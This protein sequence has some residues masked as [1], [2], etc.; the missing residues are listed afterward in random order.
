MAGARRT[1]PG[2]IVA[3]CVPR[4]VVLL[5]QLLE[6]PRDSSINFCR[7]TPW[8]VLFSVFERKVFG[9]FVLRACLRHYICRLLA[10]PFPVWFGSV[11]FGSGCVCVFYLFVSVSVSVSLFH[12]TQWRARGVDTVEGA[13]PRLLA[14]RK[15]NCHGSQATDPHSLS[16]MG[17]GGPITTELLGCCPLPSKESALS[18]S[19]VRRAP[20]HAGF[21]NNLGALFRSTRAR[22]HQHQAQEKVFLV[23]KICR[24]R[25]CHAEPN[26]CLSVTVVPW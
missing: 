2:R 17:V 18:Y 8:A 3:P 7:Q 20:L 12:M 6:D 5:Y 23:I 24:L 13:R 10:A 1:P 15:I 16:E 21:S 19:L 11:W 9:E 14:D 4:P 26:C 22:H 25:L